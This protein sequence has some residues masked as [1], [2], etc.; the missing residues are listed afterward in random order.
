M[1]LTNYDELKT[2]VGDWLNRQDLAAV[3]PDFIRLLEA[4]AQRKLRVRQMFVEVD[5]TIDTDTGRI[6]LPDDFLQLRDLR[7]LDTNGVPIGISY[8]APNELTSILR[9]Q[10]GAA[11]IPRV[12][13]V[14]KDSIE[15]V[16]TPNADYTVKLFYVRK[17]PALSAELASNWLLEEHPDIY[18]FG[19]LMQAAPYLKNDER[20]T[21]W[22]EAL[23]SILEDVRV[24]DERATKAGTPL[25]MRFRPYG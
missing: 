7:V 17:I 3:I 13:T 15:V 5:T 18:L 21:L 2:S 12:F 25:K 22:G 1:A 20:V 23:A 11:G 10:Q 9:S 19:A 16:P 4:Q 8:A 14:H 6:T 24:E